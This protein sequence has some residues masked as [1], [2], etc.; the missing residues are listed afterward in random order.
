MIPIIF[1]NI[2]DAK[3]AQKRID[4]QKQ[5]YLC[6]CEGC[7]LVGFGFSSIAYAVGYLPKYSWFVDTIITRQI[8]PVPNQQILVFSSLDDLMNSIIR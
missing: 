6:I 2:A 7:S 8:S 3:N 5:K 1:E 4:P